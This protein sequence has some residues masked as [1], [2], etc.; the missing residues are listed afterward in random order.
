M[1]L[2]ALLG[3]AGDLG[4]VAPEEALDG[5]ADD[6]R[7]RRD[8]HVRDRV[9]L[10]R[11]AALRVGVR[12]LQVDRDREEAHPV[13][14]LEERDAH[15][16]AA[17]DD[18]VAHLAPVG[19]LALAAGEDDDLVRRADDEDRS[20]EDREDA[21]RHGARDDTRPRFRRE[22]RARITSSERRWGLFLPG[23]GLDLGDPVPE[24]DDDDA[25][26]DLDR[27]TPP[28]RAGTSRSCSPTRSRIFP[29]PSGR[30]GRT[31]SPSVPR[32]ASVEA[33]PVA[34]PRPSERK[35]AATPAPTT[36]PRTT[37][38]GT[39]TAGAHAEEGERRARH[40]EGPEGVGPEAEGEEVR[41]EGAVVGVA[42]PV[43]C[44]SPWPS[45]ESCPPPSPWK[46]DAPIRTR[47][48]ASAAR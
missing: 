29:R 21:E 11:D 39:W 22:S 9:D 43:P 4:R 1:P 40:S 44:P 35:R 15:G 46:T 41:E 18:P 3:D 14:L 32:N 26:A 28:V 8:L 10:Q 23:S 5:V 47:P 19:E 6:L 13:D 42:V 38:T 7:V 16:P 45:P 24:A 27:R 17:E 30:S 33:G 48:K 37:E 36:T 25:F 34:E 20:G 31:T 12:D 2:E